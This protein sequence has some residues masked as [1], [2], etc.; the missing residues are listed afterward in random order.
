MTD[1]ERKRLEAFGKHAWA[2]FHGAERDE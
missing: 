1:D 2:Q